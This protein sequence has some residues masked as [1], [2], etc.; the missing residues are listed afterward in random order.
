MRSAAAAA[1]HSRISMAL[2][3]VYDSPISPPTM[4]N[5]AFIPRLKSAAAG[6]TDENRVRRVITQSAR[7]N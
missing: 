2:E 5:V 1:V 3:E 6:E 4:T 7:R